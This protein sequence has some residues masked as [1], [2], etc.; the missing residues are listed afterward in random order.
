MGDPILSHITATV[1]WR[2]SSCQQVVLLNMIMPQAYQMDRSAALGP[3]ASPLRLLTL[4]PCIAALLRS[5]FLLMTTSS[6]GDLDSAAP[7]VGTLAMEPC[8]P[9]PLDLRMSTI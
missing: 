1:N 4:I 3:P 9:R 7:K 5:A 2:E 6:Q 8:V